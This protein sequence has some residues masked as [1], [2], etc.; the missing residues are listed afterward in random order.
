MLRIFTEPWEIISKLMFLDSPE[1]TPG[2]S[3]E[4]FQVDPTLEKNI[5]FT[6]ASS[7]ETFLGT[8]I[9]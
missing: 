7:L 3:K 5:Q 8:C 1:H 9:I 2:T 6:F 4:R